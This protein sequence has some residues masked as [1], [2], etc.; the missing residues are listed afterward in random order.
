[1]EAALKTRALSASRRAIVSAVAQRVGGPQ[2]DRGLA[3]TVL[4][5]AD[6]AVNASLDAARAQRN[7]AY[8]AD[9]QQCPA[10]RDSPSPRAA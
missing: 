5:V 1:M 6:S 3:G 7:S 4:E 8:N 10:S 9:H 2:D